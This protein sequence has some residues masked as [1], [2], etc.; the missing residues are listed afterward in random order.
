M[1]PGNLKVNIMKVSV[2]NLITSFIIITVTVVISTVLFICAQD[3]EAAP[4]PA[5]RETAIMKDIL[6]K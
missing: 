3:T 2:I 4:V 5:W 6:R 1:L